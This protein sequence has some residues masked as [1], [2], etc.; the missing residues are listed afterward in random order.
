M[1]LK[2]CKTCKTYT[3]KN[4]CKKC[5]EK[6]SDAHYKFIKIKDAPKSDPNKV[7]KN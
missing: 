7:R 4:N 3:L 5:N 1:K 6:S 2:K